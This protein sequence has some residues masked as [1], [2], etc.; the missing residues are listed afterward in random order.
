M[1][2]T[3]NIPDFSPLTL[4]NDIQ[5]LKQTIKLS[6]ALMLFKNNKF[7]IEQAS[8]FANISIYDFMN[9]CRNNKIAI[10]SYDKKELEDEMKLLSNL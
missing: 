1:Q 4:N 8:E 2:L 5:E 3:I 9:E 6:S 7:S 10:I